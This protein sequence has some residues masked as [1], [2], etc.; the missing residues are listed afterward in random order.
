MT[1][2]DHVVI[3]QSKAGHGGSSSKDE[4]QQKC[5]D[6]EHRQHTPHSASRETRSDDPLATV[7]AL[8][9][10]FVNQMVAI[11]TRN[12]VGLGIFGRAILPIRPFA[13]VE[14]VVARVQFSAFLEPEGVSVHLRAHSAACSTP[15]V[16]LLLTPNDRPALPAFSSL[17]IDQDIGR[18]SRGSRA[19]TRERRNCYRDRRERP[20]PGIIVRLAALG[21]I[22]AK[23]PHG[24]V[25]EG[26]K[27]EMPDHSC[28]NLGR[29]DSVFGLFRSI[30][31]TL[32]RPTTARLP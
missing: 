4:C 24:G 23:F 21:R 30:S 15:A 7:R 18:T 16:G 2:A 5:E 9:R 14:T 17:R 28:H 8:L 19:H 11:G 13:V 31:G 6:H 26:G 25:L 12:F 1:S 10:F 27:W 32:R 20:T 3:V 29:H 22:W